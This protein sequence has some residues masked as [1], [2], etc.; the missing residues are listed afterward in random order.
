MSDEIKPSGPGPGKVILIV[1]AILVGLGAVCCGG[2]WFLGGNKAWPF[3]RGQIAL[4]S[5]AEETLGQG[6]TIMVMPSDDDDMVLLAGVRDLDP[7]QV[8]EIQDKAWKAYCEAFRDGGLE[9]RRIGVGTL[10]GAA[11]KD[12]EGAAAEPA[13]PGKA[14]ISGWKKNV[15]KVEDVV[16]R[17][18]VAAPP[19]AEWLRE[20]KLAAKKGGED[21]TV[22]ITIG[23]DG[24][25]PAPEKSPK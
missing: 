16:A 6:S 19:E 3:V 4:Q 7:A 14:G 12:G 21:G 22:E 8:P 18:G 23:D 5:A 1:L 15:V 10:G 11:R 9:V 17:T 20:L 13:T 25:T 24:E 2:M